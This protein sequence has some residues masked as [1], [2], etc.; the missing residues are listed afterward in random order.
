MIFH[1]HKWKDTSKKFISPVG[2]FKFK[3][4]FWGTMHDDAM[5]G[6]TIVSQRCIICNKPRTVKL[7]GELIE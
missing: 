7:S 2:S 1:I 4:G 6:Y 3:G 5:Y